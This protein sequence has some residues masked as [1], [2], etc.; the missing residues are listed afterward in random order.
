[1]GSDFLLGGNGYRPTRSLQDFV[2]EQFRAETSETTETGAGHSRLDT[3]F[4]TL[5]ALAENADRASV[6]PRG[7]GGAATLSAT[8]GGSTGSP[9]AVVAA[10]HGAWRPE[11][12]APRAGCLLAAPATQAP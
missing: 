12:E 10:M 11:E 1:V 7:G 8:G 9:S 6:L 3:A 4:A 2:R 5:A